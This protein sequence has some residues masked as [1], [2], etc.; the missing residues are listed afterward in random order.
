MDLRSWQQ[1]T[2]TLGRDERMIQERKLGNGGVWLTNL[3]LIQRRRRSQ[4]WGRE[5]VTVEIPL[6]E[7]AGISIGFLR[8]FRLLVIG[9]VMSFSGLFL[10]S[11]V[12]GG[13]ATALWL[14]GLLLVIAYVLTGRRG[15]VI[16]GGLVEIKF[17]IRGMSADD[18]RGFVFAL[19]EARAELMGESAED[20]VDD[21]SRNEG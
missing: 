7:I 16:K 5:M 9:T 2:P 3:R 10:G 12:P 6:E 4:Y 19:E 14:G 1:P 8:R 18:V 21:D 20:E 15:L 11:A 13:L 17:P